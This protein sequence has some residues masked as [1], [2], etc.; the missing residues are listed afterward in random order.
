MHRAPDAK[1]GGNAQK[2]IRICI[3]R[4]VDSESLIF[5]SSEKHLGQELPEITVSLNETEKEYIRTARI[6]Q[7][8]FRKSLIEGY[9]G[10]CP[11][12]GIEN[13]QLLIAS[14]IKPWKKCT[15]AERLDPCNGILLSALIDRLF[16]QGL[17]TF[18]DDGSVSVSSLLAES[19]RKRC[20]IDQWPRINLKAGS[21]QY[22]QFHR[23]VEFKCT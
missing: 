3:D 7:G 18:E 8:Q 1:K 20:A 4:N 11:I 23:A 15:N 16:D 21:R 17:I 6:G 22:L 14:H 19:D 9:G 5:D 12:T 10:R 2:R 13:E